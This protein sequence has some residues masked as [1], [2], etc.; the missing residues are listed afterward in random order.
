MYKKL[1]KMRIRTHLYLSAYKHLSQMKHNSLHEGAYKHRFTWKYIQSI[2]CMMN[3]KLHGETYK[4]PQTIVHTNHHAPC[5]VGSPCVQTAITLHTN[6]HELPP[7]IQTIH[8][9]GGERPSS[10]SAEAAVPICRHPQRPP[11]PV[12]RGRHPRPSPSMHRA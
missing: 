1:I 12:R 9:P 2:S 6:H 10:P 11:S 4:H 7:C 8:R 3:K 5:M